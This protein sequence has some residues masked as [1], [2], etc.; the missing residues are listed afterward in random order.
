MGN[1]GSTYPEATDD[2]KAGAK[3]EADDEKLI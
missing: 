2:E 1:Y 3:E